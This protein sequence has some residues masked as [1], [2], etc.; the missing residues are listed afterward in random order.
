MKK[1]KCNGLEKA[2]ETFKTMEGEIFDCEF[3]LLGSK[4]VINLEIFNK[5]I[6]RDWNFQNTKG[7][8]KR[9]F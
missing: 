1:S 2:T 8:L 3:E 6:D 9:L 4:N 5:V 7:C